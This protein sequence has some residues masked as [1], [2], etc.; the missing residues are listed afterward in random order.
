MKLKLAMTGASGSG[1]TY[2]ALLIAKGL[3]P[4]GKIAFIDTENDSGQLYAGVE[5]MPPF[6]HM[7]IGAP[8]HTDKYL[9]AI[10]AACSN[11]YDCLVVDSIS[12]QWSGEGGIMDRMDKD[13]MAQP[14]KNS[15]TMWAKF[16]PEHER[17]KAAIVQAPI[18]IISTMRSKQDYILTTNEKGKQTP[19]KVGMAPVQRDQFEYEFTSVFDMN[20]EHYA[21]VS[22]D[23][24][25]LFPDPFRPS[26]ETGLILKR[27]LET[28]A[29]PPAP[30]VKALPQPRQP[31]PGDTR[32]S[33]DTGRRMYRLTEEMKKRG[34]V[35]ANITTYI[36]KA[37]GADRVGQLADLQFENLIG[38]IR[39]EESFDWAIENLAAMTLA[40]A[41]QSGPTAEGPP[42][43][44]FAPNFDE[45]LANDQMIGDQSALPM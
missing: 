6:E 8:F 34:W 38:V 4:G 40:K 7:S 41:Q 31:Q 15:Y 26:E 37:Y 9:K 13:K 28:G 10:Y 22:K 5:G 14:G 44:D 18:H 17:F 30:P 21:V 45:S 36:A 11:G 39:N 27:W 19:Q 35:P 1:K 12:H 20:M 33:P 16:T 23:R 43:Q 2:S 3:S 32:V 25:N 42:P 24:T 29:E